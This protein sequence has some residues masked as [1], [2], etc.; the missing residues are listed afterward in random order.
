MMQIPINHCPVCDRDVAEW[1]PFVRLIGD[2][3]YRHEP[4]GRLCPHC[5]SF[6]RTRHFWLYVQKKGLLDSKPR[7]LHVAPERGLKERLRAVLAD[8]YVTTDMAQP[9]V[10]V[11]ADLTALPLADASFDFIYCSN[12]L[13]HVPNDRAAMTELRRVLSLGG[14][15]YIQVPAQGET[16]LEDL[17]ITDPVERARR[18]GQ[19]D[20]V[21]QYG[22]DISERLTKAGFE[23]QET[24]MPDTL[25]MPLSELKT[26]NCERRERIYLCFARA[27]GI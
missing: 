27:S 9:D 13:E 20:H 25:H 23:V 17:T 10:D 3:K 26:F 8:S 12:V 4:G 15:A 16:T 6:E 5:D 11:Q 2:G 14:T 18:Y 21:R 1:N 19:A 24:I 7:F 22:R